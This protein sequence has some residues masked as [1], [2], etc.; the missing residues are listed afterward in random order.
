MPRR[1]RMAPGGMVCHHHTTGTGHLY[2]G[3]FKAFPMQ[4][5]AHFLTVCRYVERNALR[6]GLVRR[7]EDW[8]WGSLA[9]RRSRDPDARTLLSDWPVDP[10][11]GWLRIVNEPQTEEE[12][13][14]LRQAVRRGSPFGTPT[15]TART[16]FRLGIEYT[17]RPRGRPPRRAASERTPRP[18]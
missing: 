2:Q 9:R 4:T 3:R 15:W 11:R 10:P 14:V 17:L 5:D 6:A 8:R 18:K 13:A 16:A 1:A 12:L 7:A